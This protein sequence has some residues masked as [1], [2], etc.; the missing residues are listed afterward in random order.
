M[1]NGIIMMNLEYCAFIKKM[2]QPVYYPEVFSRLVLMDTRWMKQVDSILP[3]REG[4][5]LSLDNKWFEDTKRGIRSPDRVCWQDY[6]KPIKLH[7]SRHTYGNIRS[8][9]QSLKQLHDVMTDRLQHSR[10]VDDA[11]VFILKDEEEGE[12]WLKSAKNV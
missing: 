9:S 4:M 5:M 7:L 6:P 12:K 1:W 3:R 10:K 11:A 2:R 8:Q